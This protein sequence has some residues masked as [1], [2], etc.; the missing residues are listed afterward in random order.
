MTARAVSPANIMPV[1]PYEMCSSHV[2]ATMSPN[3]MQNFTPGQSGLAWPNTCQPT[4][5]AG[6]LHG[7][8][9]AVGRRL[10]SPHSRLTRSHIPRDG[11]GRSA[12][13]TSR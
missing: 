12:L 7:D 4:A 6:I 2:S 3:S 13:S 1:V 11:S 5:S 10:T 8:I 9:A